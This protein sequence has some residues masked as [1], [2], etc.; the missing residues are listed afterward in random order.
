M[1]IIESLTK[2]VEMVSMRGGIDYGDT[3]G[4]DDDE[5]AEAYQAVCTHEGLMVKWRRLCVEAGFDSV[6]KDIDRKHPPA[7]GKRQRD[8]SDQASDS[9]S[10][11]SSSEQPAGQREPSK[12]QCAQH[13]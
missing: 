4:D 6:W 5:N 7:K 9:S 10:S 12:Q 8:A 1:G 13:E 2:L 3:E 11:A